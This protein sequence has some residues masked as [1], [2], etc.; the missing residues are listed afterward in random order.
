MWSAGKLWVA[1]GWGDGLEG[2][3]GRVGFGSADWEGGRD[4]SE[5]Y[6]QQL[7]GLL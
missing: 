1:W 6:L 4:A 2:V 3:G 5:K 7:T